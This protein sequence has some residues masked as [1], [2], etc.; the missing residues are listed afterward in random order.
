M[1]EL[2]KWQTRLAKM[3]GRKISLGETVGI[4]SRIC[5]A[6]FQLV[7]GEKARNLEELV[8]MLINLE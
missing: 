5:S 6:R 3:V 2:A 8:Q 1:A 4:L 7:P